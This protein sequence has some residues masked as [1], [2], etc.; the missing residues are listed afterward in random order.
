[1]QNYFL[2]NWFALQE[3]HYFQVNYI[4][5][6]FCNHNYNHLKYYF[7]KEFPENNLLCFIMLVI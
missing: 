2:E 1:M 4:E 6:N 3:E 7:L 5:L